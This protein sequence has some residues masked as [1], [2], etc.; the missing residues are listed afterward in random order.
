MW[1]LKGI[2]S[3]KSDL[4]VEKKMARTKELKFEMSSSKMFNIIW[5]EKYYEQDC[6]NL[7]EKGSSKGELLTEEKMALI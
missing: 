1:N 3:L 5:K 7:K 2:L 4:S 6:W